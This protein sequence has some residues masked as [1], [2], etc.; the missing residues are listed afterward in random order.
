MKEQAPF[1]SYQGVSKEDQL[2]GES[3][4]G[5]HDDSIVDTFD[6]ELLRTPHRMSK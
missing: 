2:T 4:V 5:V 6:Y 1:P 3:D